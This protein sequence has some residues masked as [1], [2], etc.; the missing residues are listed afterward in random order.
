MFVCLRTQVYVR[1]AVTTAT[2]H[3]LSAARWNRTPAK[4]TAWSYSSPTSND[5][6]RRTSVRSVATRPHNP[7]YTTFTCDNSIR[8]VLLSPARTT[9][10]SSSSRP[11][12]R[13]CCR[14]PK[15]R[16]TSLQML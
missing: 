5:V 13:R 6:Q 12:N 10:D 16:K 7:S 4:Y 15:I 8:T 3:S 14:R 2:R 9:N 1:I 11:L